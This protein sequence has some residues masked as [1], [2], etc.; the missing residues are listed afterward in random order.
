MEDQNVQP[1][2]EDQLEPELTLSETAIDYLT[3]TS[4]WT[5]FLS[6]VGFVFTGLVVLMGVFAGSLMSFLPTGPMGNM[7]QGMG[8]LFG[9][10]YILMGLLYFFPSW[11]LFKFSQKLQLAL[12]TSNDEELNTAFSNQK[13]FY[14]FYGIFVIIMIGLYALSALFALTISAFTS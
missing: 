5:K 1:D 12:A 2:H 11:Y 8:A 4:K 3:E 7:S 14:K 9:G 10:I 13:S 6:I